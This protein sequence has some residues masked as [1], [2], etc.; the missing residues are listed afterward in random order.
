MKHAISAAIA[1]L[2]LAPVA[3]AAEILQPVVVTATRTAQTVDSTLASV[4]IIDREEIERLQAQSVPDVLA[5]VPGVS[6]ANSGGP[7]KA[8]SI[9]LRGTESDHVLVLVDGIKI[10]SATLGSAALENL[11]IDSVERIEVVRGPRSSLYGS[12]AIGGV[13]QIFTRKGEGK[14]SIHG[15]ITAGSYATKEAAVGIS[16]GDQRAWYSLDGS[17]TDTDGFNACYGKP[18]PNGGG[19]FTNEAD[20]DGYKSKGGSF[21][22]GYR[23]A[24]G[25]S[26]DAHALID[27]SEVDFD[28][29][30]VNE[31]EPFQ[32]TLGVDVG[33][34]LSESWGLK[35]AAGRNTDVADNFKDGTK[36]SRF[37]V[38]RDSYSLVSDW[39]PSAS[40]LLTFGVDYEDVEVGGT[41]SY[42][43][44]Q[45]DDTG[46]F[47]QYQAN[48][49][50][51]DV[52][53]RLR[54]DDNSQFGKQTTGGISVGRRFNKIYRLTA[55]Y[56]TA[57]KAP[58]FNELYYPGFG[59]DQLAPETSDSLELG[60]SGQQAWGQWGLSLFH[61]T[62][63]D[64]IAFDPT[65]FAPANIDSARIVGLEAETDFVLAGWGVKT[66]LTLLDPEN[67]G[68]GANRGNIL[69]RRAKETLRIDVDR[70]LSRWN[71]GATL[72]AVGKRYDDL[73]NTTE[74]DPYTRLDLRA[75][76]SVLPAWLLQFKAENVFD[77][78]YETA[79]YYNQPDASV[80]LTLRYQPE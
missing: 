42:T 15:R 65:S 75:G 12:E 29:D 45:R 80:Y 16:G 52:G 39:E 79:A 28:G 36:T 37:E 38:D 78:S 44:D 10:N 19:C 54:Q 5:G 59:N 23:F 68:D 76:F 3:Q 11:P 25:F 71:L 70:K 50:G 62:V 43:E 57:F 53:L 13:I 6:I 46:L 64:L 49:R 77:E 69:P 20:K 58:T 55:S 72:L 24:N 27:S 56:G 33:Y 47:A 40:Q 14:A 51:H 41:T 60:L 48:L 32:R 17:F 18:F 7:G 2:S 67:R 74:L 73:A 26:V 31:S 22:A 30:F 4:T 66:G 61:T 21:R 9:F 63:D 35:L 8:T 1:G 34:E